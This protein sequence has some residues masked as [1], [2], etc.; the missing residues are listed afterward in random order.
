MIF[1]C[2]ECGLEQSSK[3]APC[4]DGREGCCVAHYDENSFVCDRCGVVSHFDWE[5]MPI[6]EKPG[7]AIINVNALKKLR[8]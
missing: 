5:N 6:Y 3:L 8:I 1:T 4:P 7:L 2:K